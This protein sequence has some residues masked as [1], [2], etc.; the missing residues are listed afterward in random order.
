M[1]NN[2]NII[3]LFDAYDHVALCPTCDNRTWHMMVNINDIDEEGNAKLIG[4]QCTN[5]DLRLIWK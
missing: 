4:C 1:E 3:S 2:D 5:C